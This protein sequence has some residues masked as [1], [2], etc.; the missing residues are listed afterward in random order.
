[1][2][3]REH[4]VGRVAQRQLGVFAGSQA[5]E[6]GFARRTVHARAHR[7]I[8]VPLIGDTYTQAGITASPKQS[9]VAAYLAVG[10]PAAASHRSAAVWWELDVGPPVQPTITIPWTRGS[11]PDGV[12]VKRTRRWTRGDIVRSGPIHVT[13]PRRTLLDIAPVLDD[14]TLEVVI[15]AAHRRRLIN[16]GPLTPYLDAAVASKVRGASRLRSIVRSR[17]PNRP[18]ESPAETLLY[19]VL[20]RYH[21]PTPELQVWVDTRN[22]RRRIDRAYPQQKVAIEVVGY[23]WHD[24]RLPFD[25]DK[26]RDSELADLGWDRRYI[27]WTLLDE[28]PA[29]AAWTIARAIGLEPVRW[30]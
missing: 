26:I 9:I 15:D 8:W 10:A 12:R 20:R 24:G 7:G 28:N 1:M 2:A 3:G 22:R 16:V 25:D 11:T 30:R 14:P 21:V 17:D 27:T 6:A 5:V 23:E 4:V 19:S 18:I 13:S 29:E